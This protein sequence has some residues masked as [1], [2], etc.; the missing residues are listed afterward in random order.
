MTQTISLQ[1]F[2]NNL[3]MKDVAFHKYQAICCLVCFSISTIVTQ[4]NFLENSL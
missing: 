2:L 3:K 4:E 1:V